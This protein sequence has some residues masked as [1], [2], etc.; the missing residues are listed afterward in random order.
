MKKELPMAAIVGIIVAAIAVVGVILFMMVNPPAPKS[1][2]AAGGGGPV[3]S[4]PGAQ[5]PY[6]DNPRNPGDQPKDK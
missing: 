5:A 4:G 6:G 3:Q 1:P 2:E